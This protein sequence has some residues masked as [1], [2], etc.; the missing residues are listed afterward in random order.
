MYQLAPASHEESLAQRYRF[1][2][3]TPVRKSPSDR[4]TSPMSSASRPI[5]TIET[6]RNVSGV[7]PTSTIRSCLPNQPDFLAFSRAAPSAGT[8]TRNSGGSG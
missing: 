1:G 5:R 2:E 6:S 4:M 8:A 7:M 3:L